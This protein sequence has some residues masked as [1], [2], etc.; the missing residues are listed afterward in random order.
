MKNINTHSNPRAKSSIIPEN[1][2]WSSSNISAE[3]GQV[4]QHD[5]AHH[6]GDHGVTEPVL[7]VAQD[8]CLI[9]GD[10]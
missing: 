7:A 6:V 3:L 9:L 10:E 5:G 8:W 2:C 1:S 4:R